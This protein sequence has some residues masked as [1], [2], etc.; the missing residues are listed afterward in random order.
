M[1]CT[2]LEHVTLSRVHVRLDTTDGIS[3]RLSYNKANNAFL[4][5]ARKNHVEAQVKFSLKVTERARITA[6]VTVRKD[7]LLV[8]VHSFFLLECCFPGPG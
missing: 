3:P 6:N 5:S 1:S 7:S 4:N 8:Y 2:L